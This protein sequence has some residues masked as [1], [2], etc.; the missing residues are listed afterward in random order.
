[1]QNGNTV[2][3]GG[4]EGKKTAGP[5]IETSHNQKTMSWRSWDRPI[6]GTIFRLP[7]IPSLQRGVTFTI[8][9]DGSRMRV[10]V[11]NRMDVKAH[12]EKHAG[13]EEN[14]IMQALHNLMHG[15]K[16]MGGE[17]ARDAWGRHAPQDQRLGQ[18]GA[19]GDRHNPIP[20]ARGVG[21]QQVIQGAART[22]R[23]G[24]S[25]VP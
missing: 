15:K 11:M 8:L 3:F 6:V 16:P 22:G 23:P 24:D 21:P 5:K 7:D 1:L 18:G 9:P 13:G 25:N 4:F 2:R 12:S 19:I 10:P 20:H 14:Q 17:G